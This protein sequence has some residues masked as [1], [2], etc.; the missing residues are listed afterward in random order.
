MEVIVLREL[1]V[2]GSWFTARKQIQRIKVIAFSECLVLGSWFTP[3]ET[4]TG[5]VADFVQ[6]VVSSW[7]TVLGSWFTALET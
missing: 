3:M 5:K 1:L 4:H 6:R 2:L 7:T